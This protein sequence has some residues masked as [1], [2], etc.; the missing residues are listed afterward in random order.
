MITLTDKDTNELRNI[1]YDLAC[2]WHRND[3]GCDYRC[4]FCGQEAA[5]NTDHTINHDID[6]SGMRFL[7][8]LSEPQRKL[9]LAKA[10]MKGDTSIHMMDEL[11]R[12]II[13]ESER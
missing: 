3:N 12:I 9:E 1:I 11:A 4:E 5:T 6:C 13:A 7:T 8:L 10:W 2:H